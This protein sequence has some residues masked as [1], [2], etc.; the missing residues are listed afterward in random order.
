[1]LDNSEEIEGKKVEHLGSNKSLKPQ[2]KEF[3]KHRKLK[4]KGKVGAASGK[5]EESDFEAQ[6]MTDRHKPAF[7]E[8][9]LQPIKVRDCCS[10]YK[11]AMSVGQ[12]GHVFPQ[13]YVLISTEQVNLKRKHWDAERKDKTRLKE[14][15]QKQMA[16][17]IEDAR[18][19]EASK[20]A[21]A[22]AYRVHKRRRSGG[23]PAAATPASLASLVKR[24]AAMDD[25]R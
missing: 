9:A 7:G 25:A 11:V 24:N 2:K 13:I 4:R 5:G 6:I 14:V 8:Q 22:E 21:L 16:M 15:F 23:Q 17:A 19:R 10:D 12:M 18:Q 1:M 3:L 20:G